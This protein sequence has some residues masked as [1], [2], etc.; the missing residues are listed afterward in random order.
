MFFNPFRIGS[1]WYVDGGLLSNFPSFLFSQTEFPTI[2]FRL[3]DVPPLSRYKDLEA[4]KD[5]P[6]Q[7]ESTADYLWA[8]FATMMEAQ[9]RERGVPAN[10]STRLFLREP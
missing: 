1:G 2:G 9:D 3:E 5:V 10:S 8:M 6:L 4:E 7:L